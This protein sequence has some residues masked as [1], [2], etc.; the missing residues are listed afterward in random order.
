MPLSRSA[1]T[2]PGYVAVSLHAAHPHF[3]I[4]KPGTASAL[5]LGSVIGQ[6]PS[7]LLAVFSL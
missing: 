5:P 2:Y 1:V 7:S 4:R 6:M 3:P